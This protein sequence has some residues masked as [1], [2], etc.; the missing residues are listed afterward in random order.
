MIFRAT[1]SH[2]QAAQGH[3]SIEVEA[4]TRA[5]AEARLRELYPYPRVAALPFLYLPRF[6]RKDPAR[7]HRVD[8]RAR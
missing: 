7:Y 5:E 8:L 2:R 4:P 3:H 6:D 1:W